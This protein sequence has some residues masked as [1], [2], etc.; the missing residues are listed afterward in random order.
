MLVTGMKVLANG[1]Q[2]DH[3]IPGL[4][5]VDDG[6][7]PVVDGDAVE[8]VGRNVEEGMW[9]RT[10]P[11]YARTGHGADR[12]SR[13]AGWK[14]F[15]TDPIRKDLAWIVRWHPEYG[16]SV[17]LVADGHASSIY[18]GLRDETVLWRAGGYRL[19]N[20]GIWH[21][22]SQIFDPAL[23]EYVA[24]PV[25]GAT[26][27]TAADVL[28]GPTPGKALTVLDI[29]PEAPI[30]L[31]GPDWGRELGAW[32]ASRAPEGTTPLRPLERCIVDISAPELN[33]GQML[34]ANEAAK[35]AGI[36]VATFRSYISRK[37]ND[38]PDPQAVLGSS[39]VW[40]RPVIDQW[41]ESRGYTAEAAEQ[42]VS[43]RNFGG[44]DLPTGLADAAEQIHYWLQADLSRPGP[45]LA[46]TLLGWRKRRNRETTQALARDLSLSIVTE[47]HKL[48][49]M[50]SLAYTLGDAIL[51]H[52]A[53]QAET[54]RPADEE[55][56]PS[57]AFYSMYPHTEHLLV[58]MIRTSPAHAR[59]VV[60]T[61]I[62]E[63]LRHN[64]I[65]RTDR[66]SLMYMFRSGLSMGSGDV[67]PGDRG[68]LTK[69]QRKA[70]LAT[71]VPD[72]KPDTPENAG[73]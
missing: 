33:A 53:E 32:A 41:V 61:V 22:P 40:S 47:L 45:E 4:P 20:D 51:G 55:G 12:V 5:F 71:I 14:A 21:R 56:D 65:Y 68:K 50:E 57:P 31:S 7:I 64:D 59:Y 25:P 9:G 26:T 2:T 34:N 8:A 1:L 18:A 52:M 24:R 3:P 37:E 23:E 17:W 67:G 49:P 69:E 60:N 38:V 62:G 6:H 35:V 73:R 30:T 28:D 29:D 27:V 36:S 44:Y 70:F 72:D 58:W 19:D 11:T 10:D 46:P 48:I 15:T 66:E 42:A 16:R 63:A 54:D 43:T 39:A 13:Q